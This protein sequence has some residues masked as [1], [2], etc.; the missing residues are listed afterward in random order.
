MVTGVRDDR[1][2]LLTAEIIFQ[3]PKS[4]YNHGQ[5]NIDKGEK[6]SAEVLSPLSISCYSYTLTQTF[7]WK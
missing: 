1:D 3:L 6:L 7:N 5:Q 4:I 2:S